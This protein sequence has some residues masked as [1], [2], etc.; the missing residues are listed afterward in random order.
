MGRDARAIIAVRCRKLRK[1][2]WSALGQVFPAVDRNAARQRIK[3][4]YDKAEGYAHRLENAWQELWFKY[5]GTPILPDDNPDDPQDFDL[6]A[7]ITFLRNNIDK[8][9]L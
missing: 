5:R 9:A 6:L 7:H 8:K 3:K 2:E 1:I 4:V